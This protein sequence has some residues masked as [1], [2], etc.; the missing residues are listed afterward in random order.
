MTSSIPP[1]SINNSYKVCSSNFNLVDEV[2]VTKQ[3]LLP[4]ESP[5]E[6]LPHYYISWE[7][8]ANILPKLISQVLDKQSCNKASKYLDARRLLENLP[9]HEIN[10]LKTEKERHRA[11]LLLGIFAHAW[12]W[13]PYVSGMADR[14]EYFI[15]EQISVP[16][17]QLAE[18]FARPPILTN[19]DLFDANWKQNTLTEDVSIDNLSIL[20]GFIEN[21]AE[22]YFYLVYFLM[23]WK[24]ELAIQ[25]MLKIQKSL[26]EISLADEVFLLKIADNLDI[27]AN[28]LEEI[29]SNLTQVLSKINKEEWFNK[30][31]YFSLGWNNKDMFPNGVV[32]KG[33]K[34][35]NEQGQF[36]YGPSGFQY[37][38]FQCLDAFLD[39][40]HEAYTNQVAA[41]P[42]M[43]SNQTNIINSLENS[44]K[45]RTLLTEFTVGDRKF[46]IDIDCKSYQS[47]I[48]SYNNCIRQLKNIRGLHF[49][50]VSKYLTKMI[51]QELEDK[52]IL[53]TGGQQ[54]NHEHLLRNIINNHNTQVI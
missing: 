54:N 5:L 22:K 30:V 26:K 35:Y 29:R 53:T 4:K 43:P 39:I 40:K 38:V 17:H 51:L 32:Y 3:R 8:T 28:S 24:G 10:H 46:S 50:V 27:I 48:A 19:S 41:R 7:N 34:A 47:V 9:K 33:V 15:P 13:L 16:L 21:D 2:L 37:S 42:Y 52:I 18:I 31:K 11:I 45:L 44:S 49:G 25:A 12:V 20:N 14:P 23:T 6:R 1:N 36:F